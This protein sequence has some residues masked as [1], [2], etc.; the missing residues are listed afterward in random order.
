MIS[1]T[2]RNCDNSSRDGH[3]LDRN[4]GL[5]MTVFLQSGSEAFPNSKMMWICGP[6]FPQQKKKKKRKANLLLEWM[7]SSR[8]K[9]DESFMVRIVNLLSVWGSEV[10][11]ITGAFPEKRSFFPQDHVQHLHVQHLASVL[12]GIMGELVDLD[13]TLEGMFCRESQDKTEMTFI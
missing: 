9:L 1:Y 5:V 12:R 2:C 11:L 4:N 8:V 7:I 6:Y 10:S 3:N 13:H